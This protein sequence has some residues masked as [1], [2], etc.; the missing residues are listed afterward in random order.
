MSRLV[1]TLLALSLAC[2]PVRAEA[3]PTPPAPA[4]TIQPTSDGYEWVQMDNGEWLRGWIT[5]MSEGTLVFESETF[6]E[7]Y[8]DWSSVVSLYTA[9]P[10]TYV[11]RDRTVIVGVAVL[12]KGK[13]RLADRTIDPKQVLLISAGGKNELEHWSFNFKSGAT[14]YL[15]ASSQFTWSNS[16]FVERA[17]GITRAGLRYDGAIGAVDGALTVSSH[18]ASLKV[19]ILVTSRL[20][21]LPFYGI[22]R[23][24]KEQNIALRTTIGTGGG[25]RLIDIDAGSWD[26]ELGPAYIS[27]LPFSTE[28]GTEIRTQDFGIVLGTRAKFDLTKDVKFSASWSSA[29]T[30]TGPS[31]SYH[32]GSAG[33]EIDITNI[34]NIDFSLIYNR[35]EDSTPTETGEVPPQNE[36]QLIVSLGIKL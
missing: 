11:L 4:P 2:T 35:I 1:P 26:L 22:L 15:A 14:L 12:E 27:T 29:F 28:T 16:I 31:R 6:S 18:T 5:S 25:V 30:V 3:P 9:M 32:N 20:Y 21:I 17:D 8:P 36:L 33:L 7:L 13:L 19:D 10:H 23:R 24:D 34:F